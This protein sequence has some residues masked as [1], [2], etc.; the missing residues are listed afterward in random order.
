MNIYEI[1]NQQDILC[2]TGKYIQYFITAYKGRESGKEHIHV[3]AFIRVTESVHTP[4]A[5]SALSINYT[6]VEF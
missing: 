3:C 2:S 4:E 5:N 6:S 1:D